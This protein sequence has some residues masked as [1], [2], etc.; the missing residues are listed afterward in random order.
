MEIRT[1]QKSGNTELE[2]EFSDEQIIELVDFSL[3]LDYKKKLFWR[4]QLAFL[5]VF[6]KQKLIDV[7]AKEKEQITQ[8]LMRKMKGVRGYFF[9]KALNDLESE[10]LETL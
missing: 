4:K 3:A 6:Q 7:L 2:A 8:A 10:F 1:K 9:A 5:N